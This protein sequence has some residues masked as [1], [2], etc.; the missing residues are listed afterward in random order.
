MVYVDLLVM[1][2][3]LINYV[4]LYG[5]GIILNRITKFY[6]VLF[7][8]TIG[9][10][11]LIFLF[12]HINNYIM[13]I[14]TFVFAIIMSLVSFSYKDIIYTV[15]NVIYMYL[16]SI[17]LAGSM[18]LVNTSFL[19]HINSY[20]LNVLMLLVLSPI[21]TYIYIK[22]IDKIKLGSSNYYLVDI[23][24]KD[25]PKITVNAFL[26]TGN[27]LVDPYTKKAIILVQKN[28]IGELN[29]PLLVPYET[30]TEHGLLECY[31]VLKIYINNIGYRKR[32]LIGL[33]D[34][35]GIEGAECLLNSRLLERI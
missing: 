4:I 2:D 3:L 10:I 35:V 12:C 25:R 23:Y 30:I 11:P 20:L 32:V 16:I 5:V 18:Y 1:E 21:I 9:N 26:D 29:N 28:K 7:A 31:P 8:A 27:K 15:K 6:K 14:I 19:P 33:I 34:E 13:N 17:F 22:S 24:L